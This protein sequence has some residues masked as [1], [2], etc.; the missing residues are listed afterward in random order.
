MTVNVSSTATPAV[1]LSGAYDGVLSASAPYERVSM[2]F[3]PTAGTLVALPYGSISQLQIEAG[4]TPSSYIP[5]PVGATA[6]RAAETLEIPADKIPWPEYVEVTGTELVTNGTFDSDTDWTKGTGWTISGGVATAAGPASDGSYFS[7]N[8]GLVAGKAYKYSIDLVS[9][10]LNGT[11]YLAIRFGGTVDSF[12]ITRTALLSGFFVADGSGD[13]RIRSEASQSDL[14]LDNISIKEV[15]PRAVSIHMEGDMTYADNDSGIESV[16]VGWEL[17]VNN[18]ILNLLYTSGS[19][20]GA[21]QIS[22]RNLGATG[23]TYSSTTAYSPG[24]NVPFNIASRHGDTF[25]NGAVDG[26]VLTANTTPTSLPDLSSTPLQ[27]ATLGGGMHIKEFAIW[28]EDIGDTGI[29]K[30]TT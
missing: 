15:L 28:S 18:R 7:Q 27:L 19:R 22:Q 1:R 25:I 4:S 10:T 29:G 14:V 23:V 30:V 26:T 24:I 17:D 11:N 8:I 12:N 16:F 2:S 5:T 3:T 21:V 20:T 13:F 9:G 6:T